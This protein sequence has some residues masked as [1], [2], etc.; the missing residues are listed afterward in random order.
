MSKISKVTISN[1]AGGA[2]TCPASE[3][4]IS[5]FRARTLDTDDGRHLCSETPDCFQYLERRQVV[6]AK[7]TIL[8]PSQYQFDVHN[9]RVGTHLNQQKGAQHAQMRVMLCGMVF[10]VF[11]EECRTQLSQKP[12]FFCNSLVRVAGPAKFI[13]S[14][15]RITCS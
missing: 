5:Q 11:F 3:P 8:C 7:N 9:V 4:S 15:S 6:H 10:Q 2:Y 14:K 12:S 1:I 13:Q